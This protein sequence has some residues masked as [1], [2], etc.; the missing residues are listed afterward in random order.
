M[1]IKHRE[2]TGVILPSVDVGDLLA[3][4]VTIDPFA[5]I[6]DSKNDYCPID[7]LSDGLND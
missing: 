6:D 3:I 2:D 5:Q 4:P 1:A 7:L